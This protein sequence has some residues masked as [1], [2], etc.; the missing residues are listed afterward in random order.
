MELWPGHK[1]APVT[2]LFRDRKHSD[3]SDQSDRRRAALLRPKG[4]EAP[5][6]RDEMPYPKKKIR[7]P[8]IWGPEEFTSLID[9]MALACVA[10]GARPSNPLISTL[11]AW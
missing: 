3:N 11:P 9:S 8:V 1:E 10:P 4:P 7:L 6:D 5:V 2:H